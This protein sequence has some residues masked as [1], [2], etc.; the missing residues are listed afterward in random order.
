VAASF[1]VVFAVMEMLAGHRHFAPAKFAGGVAILSLLFALV[2]AMAGTFAPL[3]RFRR[4]DLAAA[5][6]LVPVLGALL[7]VNPFLASFFLWDP[8]GRDIAREVQRQGIPPNVLAVT[9]MNRGLQY[10]LSFYLH[11][12]IKEWDAKSETGGYLLTASKNCEQVVGAQF[13]CEKEPFDADGTGRFLYLV[14]PIASGK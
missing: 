11:E 2:N 5:V 9:G 1:F 3:T 10:G 7:F 12:E 4:E 6:A 14:I 8:S 13:F